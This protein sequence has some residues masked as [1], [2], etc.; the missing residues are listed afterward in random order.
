ME[1]A[2]PPDEDGNQIDLMV[3]FLTGGGSPKE[4]VSYRITVS[5]TVSDQLTRNA[6]PTSISDLVIKV[7]GVSTPGAFSALMAVNGATRAIREKGVADALI[8]A[9]VIATN[10]RGPTS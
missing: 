3:R 8:A 5:D 1:R 4:I 9:N 10:L 6:S 2:G 7:R